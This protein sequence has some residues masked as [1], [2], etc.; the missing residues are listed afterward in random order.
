[1]GFYEMQLQFVG[2][3]PVEE[4]ED[5]CVAQRK[6]R[7]GRRHRNAIDEDVEPQPGLAQRGLNRD[8]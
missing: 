2:K 5:G 1:M 4:D 3:G 6:G 8:D 7:S